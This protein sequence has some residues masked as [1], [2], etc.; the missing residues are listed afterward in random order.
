MVQIHQINL[1]SHDTNTVSLRNVTY[2]NRLMWLLAEDFIELTNSNKNNT[3]MM[4]MN[5]WKSFIDTKEDK[6]VE[7]LKIIGQLSLSSFL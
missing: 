4:T 2:L 5:H 3:K 6:K 7:L 1:N